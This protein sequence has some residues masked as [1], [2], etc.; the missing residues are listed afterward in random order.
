MRACEFICSINIIR[1]LTGVE[2]SIG[3]IS[4]RGTKYCLA[5]SREQYIRHKGGGDGEN[6][7]IFHTTPFPQQKIFKNLRMS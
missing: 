1:I 2:G 4:P 7:I 3:Y 5:K 6:K